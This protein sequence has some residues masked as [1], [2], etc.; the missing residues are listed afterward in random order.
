MNKIVATFALSLV[1]AASAWASTETAVLSVPGMTCPVCPITVKKALDGVTGV[2]KVDV[3]F[4]AKTAQ[5]QFD[6][7]KTQVPALLKAVADA[8][9]PSKLVKVGP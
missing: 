7:A 6:D 5:V 3:D 8:G 1:C 9:Y 2:S 4:P